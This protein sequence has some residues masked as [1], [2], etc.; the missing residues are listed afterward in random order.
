[1]AIARA[2]VRQPILLLADEPTGNLDA[3]TASEVMELLIELQEEQQ[4]MMVVVTHSGTQ[5]ARLQ[6]RYV[7]DAGRLQPAD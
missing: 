5:A 6:S 3:T 7:L 4:S 2:L 1:M